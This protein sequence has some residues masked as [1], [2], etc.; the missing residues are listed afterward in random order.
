MVV[1]ELP[2]EIRALQAVGAFVQQEVYP[3][4]ERIA[5]RGSIDFDEVDEL[6]KQARAAA[7]T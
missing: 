7:G 6:R 2:E 1:P 3:L 4:E 5:A